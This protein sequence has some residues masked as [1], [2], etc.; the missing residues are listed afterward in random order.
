[1]DIIR[2]AATLQGVDVA[3]ELLRAW[4]YFDPYEYATTALNT[5]AVDR[6]NITTRNHRLLRLMRHVEFL[7]HL[8]IDMYMG[9]V[10]LSIL[11]GCDALEIL[12][13]T[14]ADR[15]R[16]TLPRAL[17]RLRKLCLEGWPAFP[18]YRLSA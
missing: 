8:R 2:D 7:A 12:Y 18:T 15:E 1:M 16:L 5:P 11:E 6:L 3:N 14:R 4:A 17:P 13:L 10:D 9:D